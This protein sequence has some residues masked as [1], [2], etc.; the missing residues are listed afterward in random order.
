MPYEYPCR[1][2]EFEDEDRPKER[3]SRPAAGP[4]FVTAA[5]PKPKK[6]RNLKQ[7][8]SHGDA[9]CLGHAS[10]RRNYRLVT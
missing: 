8:P 4:R 2:W 3:S 10:H 1:H 7:A 9:R 6:R 5:V